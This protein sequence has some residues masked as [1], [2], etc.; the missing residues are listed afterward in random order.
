[1]YEEYNFNFSQPY[2]H[3]KYVERELDINIRIKTVE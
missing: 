3:Q 2:P 1:M